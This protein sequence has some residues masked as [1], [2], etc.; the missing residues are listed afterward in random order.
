M[1][2]YDFYI[3]IYHKIYHKELG[4]VITEA[5]SFQICSV[6]WQVETQDSQWHCSSLCP[7]V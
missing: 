6:S 5:G 4:H 1:Y 3:Y 2:L 7:K